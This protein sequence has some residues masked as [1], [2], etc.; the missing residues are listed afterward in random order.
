MCKWQGGRKVI[1]DEV[2]KKEM[3]ERKRNIE[4]L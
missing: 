1:E 4:L 2:E 3:K